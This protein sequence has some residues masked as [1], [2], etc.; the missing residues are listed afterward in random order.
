MA[1]ATASTPCGGRGRV[2]GDRARAQQQRNGDATSKNTGSYMN[3]P[4]FS[5]E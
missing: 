1:A 2:V 4:Y 3:L 5:N